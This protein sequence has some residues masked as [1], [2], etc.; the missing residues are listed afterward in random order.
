[1]IFLG[2]ALQTRFQHRGVRA[3]L[4]QGIEALRA[5]VLLSPADRPR[6]LALA[7]AN[8]ANALRLSFDH[9]GPIR[10]IDEA[11]DA[12]RGKLPFDSEGAN[13]AATLC[14]LGEALASR[15]RR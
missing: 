11:V 14:A 12:F 15:Y 13:R 2:S 10:D 6:G 9:G 5:A 3:D 4:D 7:R 1:M 8:L